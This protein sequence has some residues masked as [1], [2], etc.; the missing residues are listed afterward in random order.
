MKGS[1]KL[2]SE[3]REGINLEVKDTFFAYSDE[4]FKK[5]LKKWNLKIEDVKWA[6]VG[7]YGTSEGIQAIFD[8]I[9]NIEER[10]KNEVDPQHVYDY[11]YINHECGYTGDDSEALSIVYDIY[12]KDVK[13]KRKGC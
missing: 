8:Q 5:G 11:E 1:K 2:Y 13:I 6:G 3:I 9:D 7:L 10:I 12:G 4:Q